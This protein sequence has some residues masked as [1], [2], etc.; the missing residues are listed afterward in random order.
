MLVRKWASVN[1]FIYAN[2]QGMKHGHQTEHST[3][4]LASRHAKLSFT[5]KM[6]STNWMHETKTLLTVVF[7]TIYASRA[8]VLSNDC[9]FACISKRHM[10]PLVY[11]VDV[12]SAHD[13]PMQLW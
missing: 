2:E 10:R 5:S 7:L 6:N 9:R 8:V 13:L 11:G 4:S 3:W 12:L 1:W